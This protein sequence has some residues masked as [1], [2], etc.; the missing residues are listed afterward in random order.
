M[1]NDLSTIRAIELFEQNTT[2]QLPESMYQAIL[3]HAKNTP[4]AKA[5]KFFL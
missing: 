5:I 4:N 1:K 3:T 2:P